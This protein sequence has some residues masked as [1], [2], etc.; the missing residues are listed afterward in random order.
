MY[1]GLARRNE[2]TPDGFALVLCHELAH[3]Y[4]GKPYV[5]PSNQIAA[6][7][8]AD[9]F[10]AQSCLHALLPK[11]ATYEA[12]KS[13][14]A[15]IDSRCK[16]TADYAL[17]VRQLEAGQSL[18]RL[19]ASMQKTDVP[20]YQTPDP[21]VVDRT[22]LSYPKTIQCRIDTYHNGTLNMPRPACWF[23]Q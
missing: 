5:S 21:T 13:T 10:G 19:L 23:K 17:C 14:D 6:E 22:L 1:G 7:G 15:Y 8:Q 12:H 4:G 16:T 2:V 3:A 20:D 11:I 18:G 9:Y